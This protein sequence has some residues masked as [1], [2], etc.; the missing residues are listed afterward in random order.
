MHVWHTPWLSTFYLILV[1][2]LFITRHNMV[3]EK[4]LFGHWSSS[5]HVRKRRLTSLSF[6]S[7]SLGFKDFKLLTVD[8]SIGNVNTNYAS[9]WHRSWSSNSSNYLSS[10]LFGAPERTYLLLKIIVFELSK[11]ISE[12]RLRHSIVTARILCT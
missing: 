3:Q 4:K 2:P 11:P 6:K 9:V 10:N 8:S 12:Y 7:Y 1:Y 5:W